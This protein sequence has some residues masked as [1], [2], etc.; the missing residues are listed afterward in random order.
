M[1]TAPSAGAARVSFVHRVWRCKWG[2]FRL[3]IAA[4]LL[5]AVAID[6]PARLARLELASLP[7]FDYVKEVE[8]LRLAGRYGEAVMIAKSGLDRT[9]EA[10]L[11]DEERAKLDAELTRTLSEQESWVRKAKDAGLGALS[12]RADSLEGLIGAVAAD[13][14]IVGDVRDLVIEGGKLALDGESDEVILAL[15]GIGLATT[16]APEIDWAPSIMKAAKR[17]GTLTKRFG[18]EIVTLVRQGKKDT[19]LAVLGDVSTISKKA[20]PGGAMRLLRHAESA[21]DLKAIARFVERQPHGAFA[22]HVAGDAGAT[23][24]KDTAKAGEA[25]A[26]SAT[27]IAADAAPLGE[28]MLIKAARKGER[29]VRLLTNSRAGKILLKPHALVGLAKGLWKGNLANLA[30]R[31]VDRFGPNAWWLLPLLAAWTFVE[32][33]LIGRKLASWGLYEPEARARVLA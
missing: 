31:L 2:F 30:Q 23:I 15:S 28:T 9:E 24:V 22:L 33:V 19:L 16:A 29:G 6:T 12:G 7:N 3:F 10:P 1:N 14:F 5:W 11:T 8:S 26:T 32:V 17:A 4:F 20:S 18:S 27:K 25:A 21:D 13:F